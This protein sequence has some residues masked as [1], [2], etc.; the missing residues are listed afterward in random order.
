MRRRSWILKDGVVL[1]SPFRRD[2][3]HSATIR[4]FLP[5]L[6]CFSVSFI[7]GS[8]LPT[9][10]SQ[11]RFQTVSSH[12]SP[13]PFA[14]PST[15]RPSSTSHTS[16]ITNRHCNALHCSPLPNHHTIQT[17]RVRSIGSGCWTCSSRRPPTPTSASSSGSA[18]LTHTTL[19]NPAPADAVNE[20]SF[21]TSQHTVKADQYKL[22][23]RLYHGRQRYMR[24]NDSNMRNRPDPLRFPMLHAPKPIPALPVSPSNYL[25][26]ASDVLQGMMNCPVAGW[27]GVSVECVDVKPDIGSCESSIVHVVLILILA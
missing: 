2:E 27:G 8:L 24:F 9:T 6:D 20:V 12:T 25:D 16:I 26:A 23:R 15:A 11:L 14:S 1:I 22:Q 13:A 10:F 3:E 21:S 18:S 17:H 7:F 5:V 19:S 4:I